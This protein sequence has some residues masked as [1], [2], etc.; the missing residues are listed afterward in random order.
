MRSKIGG[1]IYIEESNKNKQQSDSKTK[2]FIKSSTFINGTS[3]TGGAIALMNTHY[4]T[5]SNSSFI[6]NQALISFDSTSESYTGFEGAGGA[7]FIECDTS[8]S[9]SC[10]VQ[11][12]NKSVLKSNKALVKGGAIHWDS[13]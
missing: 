7:I 9:I 1:M 3:Q 11:I 12:D 2:Y 4:M 8:S 13:V 5:I 6:K 10:N